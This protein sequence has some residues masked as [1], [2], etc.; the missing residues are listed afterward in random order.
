MSRRNF[1]CCNLYTRFKGHTFCHATDL[2]MNTSLPKYNDLIPSGMDYEYA[3]HFR[4]GKVYRKGQKLYNHFPVQVLPQHHRL[5]DAKYIYHQ[6]AKEDAWKWMLENRQLVH[7]Y[8][9]GPDDDDPEMVENII[10]RFREYELV[11]WDELLDQLAHFS[12]PHQLARVRSFA[13]RKRAEIARLH[14]YRSFWESLAIAYNEWKERVLAV[15]QPPR[16]AG[17][18]AALQKVNAILPDTDQAL[19]E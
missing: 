18:S 9:W 19:L 13:A 3:F 14:G 6:A 4:A 2:P 7:I 16:P 10:V 1:F 11:R 5:F 12:K 15:D 8:W 17:L